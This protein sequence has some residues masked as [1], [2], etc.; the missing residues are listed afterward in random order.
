MDKNHL[1]RKAYFISSI[2][3]FISLLI[4]MNLQAQDLMDPI[5]DALKETEIARAKAYL[6]T[7]PVTVTDAHCERSTGGI[8]D[9]YS[10]GDYW[11]PNPENPGGP[12]QQ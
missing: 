8:N 3:T 7:V 4:P 5:I 9:F 10:E 1:K 12:Y 6:S 11:W 2:F